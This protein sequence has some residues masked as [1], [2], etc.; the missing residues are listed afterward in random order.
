[1]TEQDQDLDKPEK[2]PPGKAGYRRRAKHRDVQAFMLDL[3]AWLDLPGKAV[4]RAMVLA[5]D[6]MANRLFQWRTVDAIAGSCLYAA[7][8]IEGIPRSLSE[9]ME[10]YDGPGERRVYECLK[11]LAREFDLNT[12]KPDPLALLKH[13]A[14]EMGLPPMVTVHAYQLLERVLA[15][16]NMQGKDPNG[17]VAACLYRACKAL[18][19]RRTQDTISKACMVDV[20]TLRK[21]LKEIDTITKLL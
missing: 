1:M 16:K 19:H 14:T 4:E 12:R 8:K 15:V 3:A 18:Q 7:C 11:I 17:V 5:G 20:T 10:H 6:A 9:F 21:R 13:H 2:E